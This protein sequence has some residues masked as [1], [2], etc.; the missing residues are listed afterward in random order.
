MKRLYPWIPILGIVL[1]M[2]EDTKNTKLD[3]FTIFILSAL[4]QAVCVASLGICLGLI[5]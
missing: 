4:Y 2:T 3:N 1:T 5:N